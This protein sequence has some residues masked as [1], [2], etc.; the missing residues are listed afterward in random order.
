MRGFYLVQV[1]DEAV[2]IFRLGTIAQKI[3]N[4]I[5]DALLAAGHFEQ[6]AVKRNIPVP[7]EAVLG[8]RPVEGDAVRLF[9]ISQRA[10]HVEQDG[11]NCL[12]YN[13]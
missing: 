4:E 1:L 8:E 11:F 10:V 7:V 12:H 5:L 2:K 6:L 9:R 13:L 3:R